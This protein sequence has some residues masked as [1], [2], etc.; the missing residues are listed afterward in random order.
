MAD[1]MDKITQHPGNTSSAEKPMPT[2][3]EFWAELQRAKELPAASVP[4]SLGS[5]GAISSGSVVGSG[6]ALSSGFVAGSGGGSGSGSG[7]GG[8][9]YGIG[10][11]ASDE[12]SQRR[13]QA[14]MRDLLAKEAGKTSKLV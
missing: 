1:R 12:E 9:G 11:I 7:S 5:G 10:L 3:R 4:L 6:A 13:I 8:G 2:L 14:I